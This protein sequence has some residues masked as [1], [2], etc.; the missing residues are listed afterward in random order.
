MRCTREDHGA[1]SVMSN[2]AETSTPASTACVAMTM[3]SYLFIAE[4]EFRMPLAIYW[5]EARV[6]ESDFLPVIERIL[7]PR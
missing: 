6:D 3:R 7:S 4:K 5:P 1:S 2:R